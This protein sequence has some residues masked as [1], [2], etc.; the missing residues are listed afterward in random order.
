MKLGVCYY[1]EHWPPE[2]W[3]LDAKQMRAAGLSI[4]RIGEFAWTKMEPAE[5][6]YD[7]DWLDQVIEILAAEGLQIVLCTPTAAPPAWLVK[8]HPE[9]LPV[10]LQGKRRRFGSRRHYCANSQT[11]HRHTERIIS[12][13]AKRY[14][15][16]PAVIGWQLDNEFGCYDTAR[17]Y[18]DQCTKAFREWLKSRYLTI[19]ALNDAWGCV[20]WSQ[21]YSHWN[22]VEPPNLTVAEPNPSHVLDYYRFSSDS[23]LAYQNLQINTLQKYA[24]RHFITH[25]YIGD[26]TNLDYHTLARP[27]DF[28]CW[29]SYPTG[30]AEK[31]AFFYAPEETRPEFAYDAGDPGMTGFCHDLTR[32]LKQAPY[33]V[34]EQQAGNINWSIHN[35][36]IQ[37][38]LVRLWTWHALASGA[39]A[40]IY[41]RWRAALY[42]F[43]QYHSGLINHDSSPGIG[44]NDLLSMQ[45]EHDLMQDVCAQPIKP[46][47]A[48]LLDYKDLWAIQLQPHRKD[49]D[50]LRHLFVYYRALQR[51]GI[52][53]EIVSPQ[54]DINHYPIVLAPTLFLADQNLA[55]KLE[56][57][58]HNGGT[59]LMGVRSGF[60][61]LTN[62]VTPDPL[63]GVFRPLIGATVQQWHALPPDVSYPIETGIPDLTGPAT[64]WVESLL[65][66]SPEESGSKAVALAH[67]TSRPF[68]GQAA[69]TE[70]QV[71]PGRAFYLGWYPTVEQASSLLSHLLTYTEIQ[72]PLDIL[73]PGLVA[74]QRGEY[75]IL[76]NFSDQ[77]L[78]ITHS[79]NAITIEPRDIEIIK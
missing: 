37:P 49:F 68:T 50:H 2:R 15:R 41:F 74:L 57:Y 65:P 6:F 67:Y 13:M 9:V 22:E 18:C 44:Y 11:F 63:P 10:D 28:A 46:Q 75:T 66:E 26:L 35:T 72:P 32:G 25:N 70:H 3:P 34:M 17:C 54:A 8:A 56:N 55:E 76:L 47:A 33:W 52:T 53:A 40:V 58:L 61:D 29:D 69:L 36:G 62:R 27:L 45:A 39:E 7:W 48:L 73:P 21:T 23:W 24:P 79:G 5:G 78:E 60:K 38:G 59:L 12:A 77:T 71:G 16:H 4:V 42:G 14:A 64:F 31:S 30:Y 19:E 20:F 51:L 43:E 1:P